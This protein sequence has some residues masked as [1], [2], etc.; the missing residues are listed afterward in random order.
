MAK[1]T[2]QDAA[3]ALEYKE[4]GNRCFQSGDYHGADGFYTNA[5]NADPS[6]PLLYT[7]RSMSRLKLAHWDDVITDSLHAISLLP[8]NMKAYYHLAQAQIALDQPGAALVSA[9]KAHEYCVKEVQ[10][11]AKGAGSMGVITELVLRCKKEDW[12]RRERTREKNRKGLVGEM[13]KLLESQRDRVLGEVDTGEKEDVETEYAEKIEEVRR[14]AAEVGLEGRRR[15]VPDW[16]IDDITFSVMHD[17]VVTRTGQ[18]YE[19]AS[20]MEH[21]KRSPTDPLTRE[22]MRVE[23]LRPNL[24]LRAACEEFLHEN[25]WAVDW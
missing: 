14:M 22:P 1:D 21:L 18:S 15:K 20:I 17:P 4:K 6:N 9:K 19:R 23:D 2:P 5:I 25:G 11:H 12:E 13:V 8:D 7:N 16:I 24:A 10:S 3:R